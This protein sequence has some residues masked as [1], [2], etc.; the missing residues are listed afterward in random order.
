MSVGESLHRYIQEKIQ[1]IHRCEIWSD[2]LKSG[3][4]NISLVKSPQNLG[5]ESGDSAVGEVV[6]LDH[7]PALLAGADLRRATAVASFS[8][9]RQHVACA[10]V[11]AIICQ[12]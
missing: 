12:L 9:G 1:N 10:P 2:S 7:M 11:S 6:P 5:A 4:L 3:N 8:K